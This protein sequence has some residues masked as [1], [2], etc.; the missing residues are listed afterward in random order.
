MQWSISS[1]LTNGRELGEVE[2]ELVVLRLTLCAL[3]CGYFLHGVFLFWR[4]EL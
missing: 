4:E 1:D 2:A 3:I